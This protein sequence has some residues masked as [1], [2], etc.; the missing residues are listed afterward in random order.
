MLFLA[1]Y[2]VLDFATPFLP[3]A[4]RF[5][6]QSIEAGGRAGVRSTVGVVDGAVASPSARVVRVEP[7]PTPGPARRSVRVPPRAPDVPRPARADSPA[8][9][10]DDD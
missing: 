1:L 5:D 6:S 10:S 8:D 7:P 2:I 3:G 4:F 9:T